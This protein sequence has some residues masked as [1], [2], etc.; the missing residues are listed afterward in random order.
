M[1]WKAVGA[2]PRLAMATS[3]ILAG[4]ALQTGA[5]EAKKPKQNDPSRRV[6]QTITPS[7]TRLVQRICRTQQEWDDQAR[8]TQDSLLSHQRS[9]TSTS[10]AD[11][12]SPGIDRGTPR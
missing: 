1:A 4:A 12:F 9:N 5:A 6:C 3:L 11:D 2:V 7:G 10:R 8:A